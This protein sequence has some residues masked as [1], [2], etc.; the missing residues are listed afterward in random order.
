[1]NIVP[2]EGGY[3]GETHISDVF[4][5]RVALRIYGPRSAARGPAAVEVDAAV[6]QLMRGIVPVPPVL[7]VRRPDPAADVP[8]LLVTGFV[9][10]VRGDLVLPELDDAGA[11]RVGRNLG[12]VLDRLAHLPTL[13]AGSFTAPSLAIEPF[14]L[15]LTDLPSYVESRR[16]DLVS[17]SADELTGLDDVAATSQDLLD[18]A[19]RTC[20]VHSDFNTRNVLLDPGTLEVTAVLD[21]EFAHSG[22]P[23][24]DTGNLLRFDRRPSFVDAVMEW[25]VGDLGHA[26]GADLYALVDL[27]VRDHDPARRHEVTERA[28]HLLRSIARTRDLH[29]WPDGWE[30]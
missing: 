22:S 4:G 29:A 23:Y 13:W 26:R 8:A 11:A 30:G 28:H 24:T 19:G 18:E 10:G 14:P 1:M 21:W 6:L 5:E 16:D 3:S 27:A 12:R 17:W 9:D 20:F 2:A 15:E 25:G 7:E